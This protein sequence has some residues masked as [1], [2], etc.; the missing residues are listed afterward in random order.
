MNEPSASAQL[1]FIEKL[2]RLLDSGSFVATYK[3]ALLIALANVAAE[4]GFDDDR[5][6]TVAIRDL[7]EQFIRLYWTH[8]REYQGVPLRQNTGR[9]AAILSTVR[10]AREAVGNPDRADAAEWVP[11]PI[12]REA[13]STVKTMPLWKL[14]TIGREKPDPDHPDNFL[15]PTREIDGHIVLR[16]GVSAC[17]RRFRALI[18]STTQAAWADY[19]RRHNP[20]L[21][22]GSDLEAFLFGSDRTALHHLAGALVDLQGGR[23]FY[24]GRRLDAAQ[25]H[26]DHFI[27]WA[28]Y[29]MNSPF[30]LVAAATSVNLQKSDHIAAVPHLERWRQR[31]EDHERDLVG[32]GALADDQAR[33]LAIAAFS[34]SQA[35]R[36]RALG[37]LRGRELQSLTGWRDVLSA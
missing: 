24:T 20:E 26:V 31:N 4:Q 15:Y 37:W 33:T 17:L 10:K 18:I 28:K 7:G 30:N 27:P 25:A 11:E 9:Q 22:A 21:G 23:C 16:P 6:Q 5:A 29:P 19:V 3:Y 2:Q 14:Q 13:T 32:L 8:A 35:E 12:V 1:E 36:L 34:Y